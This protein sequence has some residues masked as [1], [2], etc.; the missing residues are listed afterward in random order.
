MGFV[1]SSLAG[2]LL[3]DTGVYGAADPLYRGDIWVR[4]KPSQKK[5][6]C[7]RHT[8]NITAISLVKEY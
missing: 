8:W 2:L 4:F 3:C 5:E 7:D 6:R 1:G